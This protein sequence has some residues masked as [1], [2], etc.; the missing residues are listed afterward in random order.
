M[1]EKSF[2]W[3]PEDHETKIIDQEKMQT[4]TE[5]QGLIVKIKKIIL[6]QKLG[7]LIFLMLIACLLI[8]KIITPPEKESSNHQLEIMTSTLP[9]SKGS[10]L[11]SAF[12][13]PALFNEY[14]LSKNQ[15]IEILTLEATEKIIGKVRAKKDIPPHKPIFWSDLELIPENIKAKVPTQTKVFFSEESKEREP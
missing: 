12:L 2:S 5:E 4:T 9:L 13:R 6:S 10:L 8:L 11:E 7:I 14:S 1:A 3:L 15:K